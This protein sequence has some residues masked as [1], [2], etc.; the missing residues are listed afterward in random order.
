MTEW[1]SYRRDPSQDELEA[2]NAEIARQMQAVGAIEIQIQSLVS[3]IGRLRTQQRV[4]KEAIHRCKGVITLARRLPEELLAK[5]FEHCVEDGWT[6]APIVVSQVCS[7]WRKAA[8]APRVWSHIYLDA[9]SVD[10]LGR[11]RFWLH[12]ARHAPLHITIVASW[13][14]PHTQLVDTIAILRRR[15]SQ[16]QSVKL[17]IDS[18]AVTQFALS[19]FTQPMP[20][21]RE[22]EIHTQL[23]EGG[24][25]DDDFTLTHAFTEDIAP[26]LSELR[27]SCN[28]LPGR[29]RLPRQIDTLTVEISDSPV[30][31]PLSNLALVDLLEGL[32]QLKHLTVQLPLVY[33]AQM[34][35]EDPERVVELSQLASLTLHG[36]TDLN[37]LLAHLRTQS[38]KELHLRSLEDVGYRQEPIGPTLLQFLEQSQASLEILELHDIDLSPGTFEDCFWAMPDLRSLRL[39]ES[40]ISDDTIKL[41]SGRDAMC[42]KLTRLD[43]R[44]CSHLAGKVLVD[45]VRDRQPCPLE[46]DGDTRMGGASE[47]TIEPMMELGIL[48][49]CFV[50]ERDV[51]ELAR[52]T[53]V[54]LS[55]CEDDYCRK[56]SMSTLFKL[57]C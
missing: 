28:V 22:V 53:T 30:S 36:P 11:T 12:R 41:L 25:I 33:E 51:L 18:L 9:N 57:R 24:D 40:S 45:M 5:I 47:V 52:M 23:Y 10:A 20:L 6:R 54:R 37:G 27:F 49:C 21:L 1:S 17:S 2:A 3:E 15:A 31:H 56:L 7:I 50:E 43:L 19:N 38:L 44:W 14:T 34:L 8:M 39:H 35:N 13:S 16:W 26:A 48:N 55:V 29:L 42:P 46:V 4:H 32:P